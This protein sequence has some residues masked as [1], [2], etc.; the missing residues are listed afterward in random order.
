MNFYIKTHIVQKGET[1]EDIVSQYNIPDVEMLR[2]FHNQN[3]P[4]NHN[5]IGSIISVGQEIF[6]PEKTDIEKITAIQN[7][8]E[9]GLLERRQEK[10]L[11]NRLA[12]PFIK[13]KAFL[14]RYNARE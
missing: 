10:L 2:Y 12:F 4:K 11:N 13:G 1:L 8:R 14:Q 3:V 5:H 6:I 9:K 7:S